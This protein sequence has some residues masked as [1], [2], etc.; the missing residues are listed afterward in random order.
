MMAGYLAFRLVEASPPRPPTYRQ[1][2]SSICDGRKLNIQK[3][4]RHILY[5]VA[6]ILVMAAVS[7]SSCPN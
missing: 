4:R 3:E 7:Y 2:R 1:Y 6:A 5:R